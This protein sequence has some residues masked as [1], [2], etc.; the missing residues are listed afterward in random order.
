MSNQVFL[1]KLP[2]NRG[3]TPNSIPELPN[4]LA[5]ANPFFYAQNLK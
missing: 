3:V 2:Q 1:S 4:G 5:I